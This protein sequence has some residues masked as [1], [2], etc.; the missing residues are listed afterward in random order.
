MRPPLRLRLSSGQ[1]AA[2]EVHY[3]RTPLPAERTR[4]QMLL[5]SHQ[6]L[7][8]PAIASI[9]RVD[10]AT[11]RRTIHRYEREGLR[12]LRDRP[13]PGRPRKVTPA[14]ERLLLRLIDQDPRRVGVLRTAWTTPALAEYL[15]EQ[16]GIRVS[17]DTVG[18]YL[19]RHGYVARRPTWTV[20]H[21]ARRDP[22]YQVKSAAPRRSKPIPRLG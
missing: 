21:L 19:H 22:A 13:R 1:V 9:V 7:T 4:C 3:R 16:T 8:P 11:V 10:P 2:L 17:E 5:L 20:H 6:G 18:V 15:A 12:G 14:W